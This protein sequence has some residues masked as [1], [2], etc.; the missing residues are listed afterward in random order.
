SQY[1]NLPVSA[2]NASAFRKCDT[3]T[4]VTIPNSITSIVNTAFSNC[5]ILTSVTLGEGLDPPG[6]VISTER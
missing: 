3:I 5:T 4:S 6:R 1:E 2:I